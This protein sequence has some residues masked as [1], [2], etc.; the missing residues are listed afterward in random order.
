MKSFGNKNNF[1]CGSCCFFLLVPCSLEGSDGQQNVCGFV[2]KAALAG[3]W[4]SHCINL[5]NG[6]GVTKNTNKTHNPTKPTKTQEKLQKGE[7]KVRQRRNA[8]LSHAVSGSCSRDSIQCLSLV[9]NAH[10]CT[11][12]FS[13]GNS[14]KMSLTGQHL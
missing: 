10:K 6:A 7:K 8:T 14:I 11:Q 1:F 4:Q 2:K 9:G 13:S 5:Q 12:L 3:S